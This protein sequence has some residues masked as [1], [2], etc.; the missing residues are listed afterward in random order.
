MMARLEAPVTM[1]R[2]LDVPGGEDDELAGAWRSSGR[3]RGDALLGAEAVGQVG[4]PHRLRWVEA[5]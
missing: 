4:P 3:R 1:F 5:C 2:V